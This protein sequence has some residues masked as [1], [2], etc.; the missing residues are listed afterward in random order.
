MPFLR[1]RALGRLPKIPIW[2][3][4]ELIWKPRELIYSKGV[5]IGSL[6]CMIGFPNFVHFLEAFLDCIE[7]LR[8]VYDVI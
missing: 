4:G 3:V 8:V 6:T 1:P 2:L 5:G 7:F